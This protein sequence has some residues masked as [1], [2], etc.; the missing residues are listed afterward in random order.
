MRHIVLLIWAWCITLAAQPL[1]SSISITNFP[2]IQPDFV[3][4]LSP[5]WAVSGPANVEFEWLYAHNLQGPWHSSSTNRTDRLGTTTVRVGA[6]PTERTRFMRVREL[7]SATNRMRVHGIRLS[8]SYTIRHPRA[9]ASIQQAWWDIY[10]A[11]T[12]DAAEWR[13]LRRGQVTHNGHVMSASHSVTNQIGQR[14]YKAIR[15]T[16]LEDF[17]NQ[18]SPP[19]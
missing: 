10:W 5:T 15:R 12:P 7:N 1:P 18:P 9:L 17:F 14:F 3:A 6:S 8:P 16:D 13:L 11:D 2:A 19:Q 4:I